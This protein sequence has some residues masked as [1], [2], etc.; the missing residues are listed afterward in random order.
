ME[1]VIISDIQTA[2]KSDQLQDSTNSQQD[3]IKDETTDDEQ[4]QEIIQGPTSIYRYLFIGLLLMV[5]GFAYKSWSSKN[6][7]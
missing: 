4:E 6:V 5:A 1:P 7:V 2:S 3:E